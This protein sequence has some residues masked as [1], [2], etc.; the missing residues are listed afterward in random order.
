MEDTTT[1]VSSNQGVDST[2]PNDANWKPEAVLKPTEQEQPQQEADEPTEAN[3][4]AEVTQVDE[5]PTEAPDDTSKWLQAKGIDPS[6]PEA[7][8]KLA[9][10]A[11]EAERAMHQKAQRAKELE[12][13]M[14][15]L[16]DESAEQIAMS[17]GQDP[18]LLKRLQRFEVKSTINDFFVDNPDAKQYEQDMIQEMTNSGLY[19]SP[20]AMLKAAYAMAVAKN[21]DKVKSQARKETLE[22][23][24]QKQQASV[25][26]GNATN[27]GISST[28]I[29]SENVDQLV[30]KNDL[31]WFQKHYDEINR[32]MAG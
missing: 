14:T 26:T 24:A 30:A 27:A 20:D 21:P 6:D 31:A 4:D 1:E 16:S 12:R 28:K 15:E 13:S 32:A 7:I 25:P 23:L 5:T 18:E 8:N 9:K 29:T 10:S 22:S 19:G 17:T 3:N 11:R 2:Q